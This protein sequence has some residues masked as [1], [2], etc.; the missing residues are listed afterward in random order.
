MHCGHNPSLHS[1][2]EEVTTSYQ[3]GISPCTLPGQIVPAG[4]AAAFSEEISTQDSILSFLGF[5]Q[6]RV[7]QVGTWRANYHYSEGVRS[8][9]GWRSEQA[10]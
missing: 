4:G 1:L 10:A 7:N 2:A 6:W 8:A 3:F 9:I 5:A